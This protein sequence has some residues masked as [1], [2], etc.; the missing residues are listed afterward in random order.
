MSIRFLVVAASE[1][2]DVQ[3]QIE[4]L[5]NSRDPAAVAEFMQLRR[6]CLF[7]EFDTCL[8]HSIS[9][10]LLSGTL[11]SGG[12]SAADNSRKFRAFCENLTAALVPLSNAQ[13]PSAF[14]YGA[15]FATPDLFQPRDASAQSLVPWRAFLGAGGTF[16]T[17]YWPWRQIQ[18]FVFLSLS[19]LRDVEKYVSCGYCTVQY[20][21]VHCILYSNIQLI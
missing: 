18:F 4:A 20:I 8:R 5:P 14:A 15:A 7:L 2:R 21:P 16:P 9:E 12:S 3:K 19:S 13:T 1:L 6:Q 17:M 10:Q 11:S